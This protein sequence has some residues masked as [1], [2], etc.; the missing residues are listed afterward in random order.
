M[1]NA[2]VKS[3]GLLMLIDEK[4]KENTYS[5]AMTCPKCDISFEELQP[6]MFSF[7]T[8][9]GAC[10]TCSGLGIQME[11]DPKLIIPDKSLTIA[12]GAIALYRNAIDGWRGQYIGAVA[13]HFGF[14]VFTPIEELSQQQY[15][16]LLY[17]TDERIKFNMSMKNGDANWSSIGSWEGLVPQSERLYKQTNSD[18]RRR[19]LEKF[20]RISPCPVCEGKRLKRKVLS[21]QWIV[22]R[23]YGRGS[24]C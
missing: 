24:S 19:E 8:P 3:K 4:D 13:N 12:D 6:R 17:G 18:Y 11:F 15:D 2:I 10:G 23:N 7:N 1:E 22:V 20:M 14:G 5:A 16:I 9:F 21:D